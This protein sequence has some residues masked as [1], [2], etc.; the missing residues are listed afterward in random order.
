MIVWYN[1]DE[2]GGGILYVGGWD[3]AEDISGLQAAGVSAQLHIFL[4]CITENIELYHKLNCVI[5]L[6]LFILQQFR[7]VFVSKYKRRSVLHGNEPPMRKITKQF[8]IAQT[9]IICMSCFV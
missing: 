3:A 2:V 7:F 5:I 1:Q 9:N 8:E 4:D 6:P